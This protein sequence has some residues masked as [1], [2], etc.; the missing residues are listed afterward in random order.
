MTDIPLGGDIG[1]TVYDVTVNTTSANENSSA[2]YTQPEVYDSSHLRELDLPVLIVCCLF[3]SVTIILGIV[4]NIFVFIA[5]YSSKLLKTVMNAMLVNLAIGDMVTA[6]FSAPSLLVVLVY[7]LDD[8]S[9]PDA[10]CSFQD[11]FHTLGGTVQ[12]VSLVCISFERYQA[13][14]NPFEIEMKVRRVKIGI[15]SSWCL[16]L[17]FACL[18]TFWL[19]TTPMWLFCSGDYY[20][21]N[22]YMNYY[23]DF[24]LGPTSFLVTFLIIFLYV[25]ILLALK[26]HLEKKDKV[27][28][29]NKVEPNEMSR[30]AEMKSPPTANDTEMQK[31]TDPKSKN[32]AIFWKNR[33]KIGQLVSSGSKM[34]S[35]YGGSAF[36]LLNGTNISSKKDLKRGSIGQASV[37]VLVMKDENDP[38][39][40]KIVFVPRKTPFKSVCGAVSFINRANKKAFDSKSPENKTPSL[41]EASEVKSNS[42][43]TD[44]KQSVSLTFVRQLPLDGSTGEIKSVQNDKIERCKYVEDVG[45]GDDVTLSSDHS[46]STQTANS[47]LRETENIVPLLLKNMPGA[48][49]SDFT[50]LIS[51]PD[52]TQSIPERDIMSP[53]QNESVPECDRPTCT[54]ELSSHNTQSVSESDIA[55]ISPHKKSVPES[56]VVVVTRSNIV[57][58]SRIDNTVPSTLRKSTDNDSTGENRKTVSTVEQECLISRIDKSDI[59]GEDE[60][61]IDSDVRNEQ[62]S[63]EVVLALKNTQQTDGIRTVALDRGKNDHDALDETAYQEPK[64]GVIVWK[65]ADETADKNNDD[66]ELGDNPKSGNQYTFSQKP[67]QGAVFW[68]K[69]AK[70]SE[71]AADANSPV[72]FGQ[73]SAPPIDN[74]DSHEKPKPGVVFW[75]KKYKAYQKN[76][77]NDMENVNN[78]VA[79]L[80]GKAAVPGGERSTTK[81]GPV[82][83]KKK[84]KTSAVVEQIDAG[85]TVAFRPRNKAPPSGENHE[86]VG[87]TVALP[88]VKKESV[89]DVHD[90]DGKVMLAA[91]RTDQVVGSVCVMSNKNKFKGKRKLEGRTAKRASVI[92]IVFLV[93]WLPMPIVYLVTDHVTNRYGVQK[94]INGAE[95][96]CLCL[97]SLTAALNPVVFGLVNKQW[98]NE[99]LKIM[100]KCL[101]KN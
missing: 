16:G 13:I 32:N 44:G 86:P 20:N 27:L 97:A 7:S 71:S 89:I 50:N 6:V 83:W 68:K 73:N 28:K 58:K 62:K 100:K 61:I 5:I 21:T 53:L 1:S 78:I 31:E 92:I 70:V 10:F 3:L 48:P 75:E 74:P 19:R 99:F 33:A 38:E 49:I 95:L 35:S 85:E 64:E 42:S 82:F 69:K 52:K 11:F 51:V 87:D 12:L 67:K 72:P 90:F 37:D 15:C 34:S 29:K 39:N 23:A 101:K 94:I 91:A 77:T 57:P 65:M 40:E 60:N 80:P 54:S 81:Q 98:R 55:K 18:V 9:L 93:C 41:A 2:D 30:A 17:L 63:N 47:S 45:G 59:R 4:G 43:R 14:A 24:L 84:T 25:K 8:A 79:F 76:D 36:N 66:V 46:N 56:E 26:Q 88:R 96:F 22:I